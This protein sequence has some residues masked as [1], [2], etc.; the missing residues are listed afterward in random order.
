MV[1]T[2]TDLASDYH[3]SHISGFVCSVSTDKVA[4]WYLP[5]DGLKLATYNSLTGRAAETRLKP[6][7]M[8]YSNSSR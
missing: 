1:K 5:N 6:I 7:K 4:T 3:W 2:Y 8:E